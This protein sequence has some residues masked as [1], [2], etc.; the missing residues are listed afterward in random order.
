MIIIAVLSIFLITGIGWFAKKALLV[1]KICPICIGVSGTWLWMLIAKLL[2]FE[3]DLL[4][5]AIL[6]GGSVVGIAYQLA[7]R[8]PEEKA[9]ALKIIII[10]AGFFTAYQLVMFNWAA[11]GIS[12]AVIAVAVFVF[13]KI[14]APHSDGR[15]D[16]EVEELEKKMKDCC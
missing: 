7:K 13:F 2:G 16:K 1:E 14:T 5:P 4:I 11:F 6:I 12:A 3:I 8:V 9:L 15:K 10:P